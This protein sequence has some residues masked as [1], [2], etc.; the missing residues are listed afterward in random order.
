MNSVSAEATQAPSTG[1]APSAPADDYLELL[2]KALTASLYDESAWLRIEATRSR[3]QRDITR[4]DQYLKA[5]ARALVVGRLQKSNLLLAQ[6]RAFDP[7]ARENGVDWPLFGYTMIGHKRLDNIQSCVLDAL[8]RGI[9]GDLMETGVWRGGASIFMR[10]LL[11]SRGVADRIVWA[12]D[13]FKGL[14]PPRDS[15][16]GADLSHVEHLA[17]SLEQV[18]ANF[19]RFGLLDDQVRF[20]Q[21]WFCDTL[22]TAPVERLA[23]L[24]LDGDLYSS[25]M[26][27]LETMYAKVSPGGY[28]IVDD[29]GS[30][31]ECKRAVDEYIARNNIRAD[32]RTV[33]YSGAFWRV[34]G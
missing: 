19:A 32:I 3:R 20:L 29:Y 27:V 25:T 28:V 13:S 33:D 30:W 14:P 9:P 4:F 24:R 8:D 23:V 11:K 26:D 5:L 31:P 21:G 12:A 18:K 6:K 16:D 1:P 10:A 22:P 17:V 2:K 15:E 7:L 34:E